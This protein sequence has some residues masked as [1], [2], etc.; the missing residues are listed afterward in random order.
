MAASDRASSIS[1]RE[2]RSGEEEEVT[3]LVVSSFHRHVGHELSRQGVDDFL[4]YADAPALAAR[5]AAG[6]F[7]LVAAAGGALL[8]MIEVRENRH[9]S[10]LF[11]DPGAMGGG[12]G[13]ALYR[14]AER[15]MLRARPDLERI[16]VHASRYAV[17]VYERF[18]F[19]ATGAEQES[20]GVRFIPMVREL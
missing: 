18:G 5:R 19:H 4:R 16:T 11:V 7:T 2:M 8:G 13:A 12:V 1:V 17:P 3:A 10:M 15:R 6:H 20:N 14:E 9:V